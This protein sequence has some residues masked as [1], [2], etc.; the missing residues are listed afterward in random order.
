[1]KKTL[2]ILLTFALLCSVGSAFEGQ[3]LGRMVGNMLG[4]RAVSTIIDQ[5]KAIGGLTFYGAYDSDVDADYSLGSPTATFTADR[6]ASHPATYCDASG[7]VQ[8]TT[9]S[10]A[11]RYTK[12]YYDATGFHEAP[13]LLLEGASTNYCLYSSAI[14]SWSYVDVNVTVASNTIVSP[15]GTTNADRLTSI[16]NSK[17]IR[18]IITDHS[19]VAWTASC[20]VKG[21]GTV[22]FIIKEAGGD[23]TTYATKSITLTSEWTRYFITGTKN[24]ANNFSVNFNIDIADT[25]DIWGVQLE[26][27][28]YPSSF[29]P[30]T[31]AALTRNAEALSGPVANNF[32]GGTDNALQYNGTN[33]YITIPSDLGSGAFAMGVDMDSGKV[34]FYIS[35]GWVEPAKAISVGTLYHYAV[36][37]DVSNTK[38]I[39]YVNGEKIGDTT[40]VLDTTLSYS[41]WAT[42]TEATS[43]NR[44]RLLDRIAANNLKVG[45]A[46]GG[47]TTWTGTIG[48][49]NI[50]DRALTPAE[51][52][53]LA[54]GSSVSTGLVGSWIT[55][56]LVY[57][58]TE[59]P[60]SSV[61]SNDGT[62]TGATVVSTTHAGTILMKY[63]PIMLIG[64]QPANNTYLL[65]FRIE[66]PNEWAL[67]NGGISEDRLGLVTVSTASS[68]W[69][70]PANGATTGWS[71][72][73]T[74]TIVGTFSTTADGSSN[75]LNFYID[76]S[77]SGTNA[78]YTIPVGTLPAT[79]LVQPT[80]G[81]AMILEGIALYDKRLTATEVSEVDTILE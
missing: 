23:Y 66:V 42:N 36:V 45:Y 65:D 68:K 54:N 69:A 10:N 37:S 59:I 50:Y 71:R 47:D 5:L 25:L 9:T 77:V 7:V 29:I 30:T 73:G 12:G 31:T 28:S 81:Q 75:K 22:N 43:T 2:S 70:R 57:G 58:A 4:G 18:N 46:T 33:T 60:D 39:F 56:D 44:E 8:T 41:V 35:D 34:S 40:K 76:G 15:D 11:P 78:D 1:M 64:E 16:A 38:T 74:H 3:M 48:D 79:F 20:F 62:I 21:T 61:G 24:D 52:L 6:D 27:A 17:E 14:A 67:R 72:Y 19:E 13:G 53:S 26:K 63:R 55:K 49:L 51:V 80:A 32:V